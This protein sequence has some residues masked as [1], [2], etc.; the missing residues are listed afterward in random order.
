VGAGGTVIYNGANLPGK[1]PSLQAQVI[2][3][4]T[5]EIADK[6]GSTKVANMVMLGGLLELTRT[7]AQETAIG[8]LRA[9]VRN[10]KLLELDCKAIDAGMSYVRERRNE[11]LSGE[12][13]H[14]KGE[15]SRDCAGGD[16]QE[17]PV[18]AENG[19]F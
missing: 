8:V 19:R 7:L 18:L 2:C 10:A 17:Q 4:P 9:K 14:S 16:V 1:F 15:N 3:I 11:A 5:V 6:L 13:G 12:S